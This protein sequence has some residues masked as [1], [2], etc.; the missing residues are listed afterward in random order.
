MKFILRTL[1]ELLKAITY[2]WVL[3][4]INI[5]KQ[6]IRLFKL[7][8]RRRKLLHGDKNATNTGC[9]TIDHPAGRRADPLIYSQKYLLKL[10]LAVTW[11]N[12]DIIL[13]RNGVVVSESDLLPNTEYEI[14]RKCRELSSGM[15]RNDPRCRR[16]WQPR[17]SEER[18]EHPSVGGWMQ[19]PDHHYLKQPGDPNFSASLFA[20]A[21][22]NV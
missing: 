13:L 6:F 4:I 5:A 7:L 10:G 1:L 21:L 12:P 19:A 9:G 8:C 20:S 15:V 2:K 3:G 11:D 22:C 18:L 16:R 17:R 14:D